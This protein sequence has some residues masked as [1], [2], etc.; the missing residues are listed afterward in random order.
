MSR[1]L[2]RWIKRLAIA[3]LL[4]VLASAWGYRWVLPGVVDRQIRRA[5]ADAGWPDASFRL[6]RVDLW[7]IELADFQPDRSQPVWLA[8]LQADYALLSLIREK[9]VQHLRL[10]GLRPRLGYH[11][12]VWDFGPLAALMKSGSSSSSSSFSRSL[13]FRRLSIQDSTL[14]LTLDGHRLTLP[15]QVDSSQGPAGQWVASLESESAIPIRLAVRLDSP[16]SGSKRRS[17]AAKL[18]IEDRLCQA[19]G[20]IDLADGTFSLSGSLASDIAW[21]MGRNP[22][23]PL[24]ISMQGAA[25]QPAGQ[26]MV[27][28]WPLVW[29]PV[30]VSGKMTLSPA[31]SLTLEAQSHQMTWGPLTI[32]QPTLSLN[33]HS[34]QATLTATAW[35]RWRDAAVEA[36][37]EKLAIQACWQRQGEQDFFSGFVRLDEG[38]LS[39]ANRVAIDRF[40]LEIP[41]RHVLS[42]SPSHALPVLTRGAI[43]ICGL[44]V[45]QADKPAIA[46]PFSDITG[47]ASLDQGQF[48]LD[49]QSDR[50]SKPQLQAQADLDWSRPWSPDGQIRATLADLSIDDPAWLSRMVPAAKEVQL[51]GQFQG[52][53]VGKLQNGTFRPWLTLTSKDVAIS[54]SEYDMEIQGLE[55]SVHVDSFSPISTPPS[56]W[57][58]ARSAQMGKFQL[59]DGLLQFTMQAP[60]AYFI[61]RTR[62][63]LG[64]QGRF[65]V[66]GFWLDPLADQIDLEVFLEEMDLSD[67]VALFSDK[68]H[69]QG[70][71]YGRLPVAILPK[72]PSPVRLGQGF[73]YANPEGG[74]I[75]MADASTAQ[76]LLESVTDLPQQV[77]Q[78]A[79]QAL[80]DFQYR[81]L[82]LELIPRGADTSVRIVASGQGRQSSKDQPA[83]Q[84]GRFELNIHGLNQA[85]NQMLLV[86]RA[87]DQVLSPT[88]TPKRPATPPAEVK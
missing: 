58:T 34:T 78:R 4:L 16:G 29:S 31:F 12:G 62:W 52:D 63:R 49:I 66:H 86:K 7:H 46:L 69:G 67:W 83:V 50:A 65:W 73:L 64:Q 37:L 13:P 39:A 72:Q 42:S 59:A 71:M 57:I 25:T 56:Q 75:Q 82:K 77:Q 33:A 32:R 43:Q 51:T 5:L 85:I 26:I 10:S 21:Q 20:T 79:V 38:K 87:S 84:I 47:G 88:L 44:V 70:R 22:P 80:Q 19:S 30:S 60:D 3:G 53:F 11:D 45:H 40:S 18:Q 28:P 14:E 9:R 6:V 68:V 36:S 41:W 61:E 74:Y 24:G 81:W 48:H 76:S 23:M 54:S 1:F 35:A 15:M 8:R 55:T 2:C 27:S 17:I